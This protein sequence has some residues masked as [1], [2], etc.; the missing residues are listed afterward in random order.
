VT[1]LDGYRNRG[2]AC[3]VVTTLYDPETWVALLSEN[4]AS[5]QERHR[6]EILDLRPSLLVPSLSNPTMQ[7]LD[8]W[9]AFVTKQE[10]IYRHI[11]DILHFWNPMMLS[12]DTELTLLPFC[13][14][15]PLHCSIG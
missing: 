6:L 2:Q 13:R 11:C 8:T 14:R 3:L 7:I 9:S 5:S 4:L 10:G 1:N 15:F 12:S